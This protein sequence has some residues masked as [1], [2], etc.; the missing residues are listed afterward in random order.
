V[1]IAKALK[2]GKVPSKGIPKEEPLND[3][4][5]KHSDADSASETRDLTHSF[6]TIPVQAM[7]K[8][9]VTEHPVTAQD[10]EEAFHM[11]HSIITNAQKHARFAI[12]ALQYDDINN[13]IENLQKALAL[14]SPYKKE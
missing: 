12:S 10:V 14:I 13:A 11:D 3:S 4:E 5:S 6:P 1:D 7:D 2:E 8:L 9:S